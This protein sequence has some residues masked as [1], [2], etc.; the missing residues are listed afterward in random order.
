[1]ENFQAS[2]ADT[3]ETPPHRM[4]HRD[5]SLLRQL[6]DALHQTR[7]GRVSPNPYLPGGQGF[8]DRGQTSPVILMGMR[9]NEDLQ[10]A[11]PQGQ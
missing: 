11:D 9:Q 8:Q 1:M 5:L 6:Q 4:Q 7:I 3:P 2:L 10:P